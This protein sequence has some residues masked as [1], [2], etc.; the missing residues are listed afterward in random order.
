MTKKGTPGAGK[1][2]GAVFGAKVNQKPASAWPIVQEILNKYG[3]KQTLRPVTDKSGNTR[4]LER[5]KINRMGL[6]DLNSELD[7]LRMPKSK[8]ANLMADML[9]QLFPRIIK[10]DKK[11]FVGR[12]ALTMNGKTGHFPVEDSSELMKLIA[13]VALE[14]YKLEKHKENFIFFNKTTRSFAIFRG[15]AMEQAIDDGTIKLF[16]GIDWSDGQ[17]PAAPK[18]YLP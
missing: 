5:F 2:S 1:P 18:M 4:D 14:G 16:K 10:K 13:K 17:Y 7:N 11:E 8:R 3:I 12:V 15:E 6:T 9:E